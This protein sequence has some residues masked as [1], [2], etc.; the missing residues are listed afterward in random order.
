[1]KKTVAYYNPFRKSIN[2][3]LSE[4]DNFLFPVNALIKE[5]KEPWKEVWI[6]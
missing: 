3:S 5:V 6:I 4:A 1:L 2:S